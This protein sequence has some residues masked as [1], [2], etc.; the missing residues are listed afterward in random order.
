[1]SNEA[2]FY[3]FSDHILC[4]DSS[5]KKLPPLPLPNAISFSELSQQDRL[6]DSEVYLDIVDRD[7]IKMVI[8]LA[9]R[10]CP[11]AVLCVAALLR[12]RC[13]SLLTCDLN[14]SDD[15]SHEPPHFLFNATFWNHPM[16]SIHSTSTSARFRDHL[17]AD[18]VSVYSSPSVL[19]QGRRW[20]SIWQDSLSSSV[21]TS[22][23]FQQVSNSGT[24]PSALT[25][26]TSSASSSSNPD[27]ALRCSK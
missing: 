4:I 6:L 7:E 11:F 24:S 19:N 20:P 15:S 12:V 10:P 5:K 13:Y 14:I 21:P 1:M 16:Y 18:L 17:D 23:L 25:P 26:T 22:I 9:E 3:R 2:I 8:R 27:P